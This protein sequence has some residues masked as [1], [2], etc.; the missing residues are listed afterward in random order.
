MDSLSNLK[1]EKNKKV[2]EDQ[3]KFGKLEKRK[4]RK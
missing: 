2:G 1:I 4:F 3:K